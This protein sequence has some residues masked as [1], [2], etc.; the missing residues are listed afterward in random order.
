MPEGL[1]QAAYELIHG[2]FTEEQRKG[3]FKPEVAVAPD[4]SP[5]DKLLAYT[6]RDPAG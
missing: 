6:G 1:P 5:Q 2:A 3:I 4:A